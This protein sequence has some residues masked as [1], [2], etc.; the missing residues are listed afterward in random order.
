MQAVKD[1]TRQLLLETARGAFFKKGYKAVSMR[2]ISQI[3][4]VGL[5]NIYNYYDNKDSL[6]AEVLSPLLEAM[7]RMLYRHI[8]SE[9]LTMDVFTSEEIYG[10][11]LKDSLEIVAFYRQE[12]KLLLSASQSPKFSGFMDEWI[13]KGTATGIEYMKQ[14]K[15]HYPELNI[16]ISPFFIHFASSIWVN[17]LK[18]II[19][20]EEL[21]MQEMECFVGEYIRFSTGGWEKLMRRDKVSTPFSKTL[22]LKRD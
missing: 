15:E 21:S 10:K 19:Q 16:N 17:M 20:Y 13:D 11:W 5:S 7:D 9:Y 14:M 6:L 12:L 22:L 4:G 1:Y 3:S 8:D 18:E 2:E